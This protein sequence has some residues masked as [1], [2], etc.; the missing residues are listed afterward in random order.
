MTRYGDQVPDPA[1]GQQVLGREQPV[2]AGQGHPAA[3]RHRLAEQPGAQAAGCLGRNR[4]GEEHLGMRTD[5]RPGDLQG[6]RDLKGTV[7]LTYIRASI[8]ASGPTS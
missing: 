4:G 1:D 3:Q 8:M 2:A 6:H 5:P 7:G